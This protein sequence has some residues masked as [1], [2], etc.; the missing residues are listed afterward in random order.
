MSTAPHGHFQE[1]DQISAIYYGTDD[2]FA[3]LTPPCEK[4][5]NQDH[6]NGLYRVFCRFE[7]FRNGVG[8][9]RR[10]RIHLVSVVGGL[11]GLNLIPLFKPRAMTFFD[12]N[13]HAVAFFE[14]VRGVWMMSDNAEDFLSRLA[15]G[16]YPVKDERDAMLRNNLAAK[17]GEFLAKDRGRSKRSLRSSWRYALDH[18]ELTRRLLAETPVATRVE[19]ITSTGF[20]DFIRDEPDVWLFC[21][22]VFLFVH[23]DLTFNRPANA[24]IFST[25][26]DETDMLDLGGEGEGPVT[27]QCRRHSV[28]T[29]V[30]A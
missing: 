21:S 8:P 18:F 15:A 22:N 25:F 4:D 23:P 28:V 29:R 11:Y 26:F 3:E 7:E 12:I 2:G 24:A 20:V 9:R 5:H 10:E 27:V 30:T 6:V 17:A 16:A 1:F 14:L 19:G 13:P